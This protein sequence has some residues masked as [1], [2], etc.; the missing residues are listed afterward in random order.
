[1]K[2]ALFEDDECF[3]NENGF[4]VFTA[5]YLLNRGYCCGNGC[6]HCPFDYK[7]VLDDNKRRQLIKNQTISK[8]KE[9]ETKA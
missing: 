1:M 7:N 3:S 8:T 9:G 6:R 2:K 4:V 5:A